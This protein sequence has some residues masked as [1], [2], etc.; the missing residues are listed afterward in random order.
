MSGVVLDSSCLIAAAC[1][2]HIHHRSTV[3]DIERRWGMGERMIVPSHAVLEAHSV[4][5]RLPPPFRLLPREAAHVL[6]ASWGKGECVALAPPEYWALLRKESA[7][8]IG[9]CRIHDAVIARCAR[10]A[11][12]DQILTWNVDHFAPFAGDGLTVRRPGD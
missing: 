5:S 3:E 6:E 12:A 11:K 2:W 1:D 8:G 9:G 10:K 7:R 4:L